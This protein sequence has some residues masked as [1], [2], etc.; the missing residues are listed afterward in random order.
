MLCQR[1]EEKYKDWNEN[2]LPWMIE[3]DTMEQT[4]AGAQGC[5]QSIILE[6][7]AAKEEEPK[8]WVIT[9]LTIPLWVSEHFCA[10]HH[11]QYHIVF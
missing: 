7:T 11:L 9:S 1:V 4:E 3:F 10:H 5:E 2:C 8:G 6:I